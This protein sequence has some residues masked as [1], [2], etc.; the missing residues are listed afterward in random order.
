MI[1]QLVVYSD[2][3]PIEHPF[4]TQPDI[5]TLECIDTTALKRSLVIAEP[6]IL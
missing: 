6:D 2:A 1:G 3:H 4:N 5:Y